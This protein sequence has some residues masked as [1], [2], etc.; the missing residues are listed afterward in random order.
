LFDVDP[1]HVDV[2]MGTFTKSFGAAG[3]YIAGS[4]ALVDSF[5]V[6]GQG[7]VYTEPITPAICQQI[8]TS[9]RI[10][11]GQDGTKDGQRRLNQ[12]REN[13]IYF[14]RRLKKMGFIVYGDEGS[15]VIPM[16][17]FNPAKIAAFSR[18]ALARGLAVVVVGYPA[19]PVITSRAR[20]C[21]SAAHNKAILDEALGKISEIGDLLQMKLSS[22]RYPDDW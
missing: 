6:Q 5:R 9:M 4:R 20:F 10:I 18:E 3:G 8:L 17:I 21:I 13:S 14:M 11:A 1:D 15:P 2:L 12:I 22:K 7:Y 16:L 19:T